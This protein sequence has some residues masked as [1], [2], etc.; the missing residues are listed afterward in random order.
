MESYWGQ[1]EGRLLA[2][3]ENLKGLSLELLNEATLAWIEREY[4]REVHSETGVAPLGRYLAGP[5]ASLPSPTSDELRLAFTTLETR[6]QRKSDGTL[7]LEGRRL[8]VPSR[9]RHL[10][11]ISVRWARWDQSHVWMVDERTSKVLC[12]LLPLDRTAN[13]EGL[14][15]TLGPVAEPVT[16]ELGPPESRIAPLLKK[17]MDD[18]RSTGLP[19]A[20]LPKENDR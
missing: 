6:T 19:P 8:E 9:Y 18:Y 5:D 20:Y 3:L 13:A 15:R 14:R 16:T 12:R 4:H 1:V 17:L 11:R 7:S 2:M 10:D